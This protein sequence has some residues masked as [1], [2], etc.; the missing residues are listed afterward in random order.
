[1]D[2]VPNGLLTCYLQNLLRALAASE[3]DNILLRGID[4]VVL[5]EEDSIYPVVLQGRKLHAQ[6]D[7]SGELFLNH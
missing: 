4:I 1:M 7:W 2:K 6:T 5:E 3:K